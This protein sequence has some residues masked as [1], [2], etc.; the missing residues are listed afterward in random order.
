MKKDLPQI[1]KAIYFSDGCSGQYKN[2]KKFINLLH[3][4]RDYIV[5]NPP[6]FLNGS[7]GGSKFQLPT[8]EGRSEKLKKEGGSM[9]QGQGHV[10]L[11]GEE[12]I[13]FL[14]I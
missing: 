6:F 10:F 3:H 2:H 5:Q 9:V 1:E 7:G 4:Y 12:L 8:P 11:K 14:Y 13:L